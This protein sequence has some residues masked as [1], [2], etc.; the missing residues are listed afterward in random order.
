MQRASLAIQPAKV[1][2]NPKR[3]I[4][5]G[6]SLRPELHFCVARRGRLRVSSKAGVNTVLEDEATGI[7]T[8]GLNP[9]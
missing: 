9:I 1:I 6:P 4:R 7:R 2:H 5:E 3:Q 8:A